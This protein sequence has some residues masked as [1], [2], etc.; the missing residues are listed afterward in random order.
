ME[1][2]S[3]FEYFN[4]DDTGLVKLGSRVYMSYAKVDFLNKL[5]EKIKTN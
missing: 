4:F 3:L 2:L 1:Q 5:V